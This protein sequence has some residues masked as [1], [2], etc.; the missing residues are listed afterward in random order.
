MPKT[1]N[2]W[3]VERPGSKNLTTIHAAGLSFTVKKGYGGNISRAMKWLIDELN[4]VEAIGE[5]GWDGTYAYRPV[6]GGSTW[7]EHAAGTALDW[8]AAQHPMGVSRTA[9]WSSNQVAQ[10]RTFLRT[11]KG[12]AFKWG[13]DFSHRPDAMHFEMRSPTVWRRVRRLF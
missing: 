8:N 6:R 11:Q 5:F 3:Q 13:A 10:I 4:K 7:S 9:G 2:G 1:G 12:S